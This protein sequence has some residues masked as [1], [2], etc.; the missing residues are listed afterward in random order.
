MI[1]HTWI[2]QALIHDLL[3]FKSNRVTVESLEESEGLRDD[4]HDAHVNT[5]TNSPLNPAKVKVYDLD[6]KDKLW[7]EHSTSPFPQAALAVSESLAEYNAKLQE[8][9]KSNR[10]HANHFDPNGNLDAADSAQGILTAVTE[11]PGMTERK[12]ALDAHTC[13]ATA[14][15]D[16]IKSRSLDGYFEVEQSIDT[17]RESEALQNVKKLL[18]KHAPGTAIDKLRLLLTL[19]LNRPSLSPQHVN[20]LETYLKDEMGQHF[21]TSSLE[22]LRQLQRFKTSFQTPPVSSSSSLAAAGGGLSGSGSLTGGGVSLS[23]APTAAVASLSST[24]F[25]KGR[26]LLQGVKNFLPAKKTLP[27][28]QVIESLIENSSSNKEDANFLYIDPAPRHHPNNNPSHSSHPPHRMASPFRSAVAFVLG[29]GSFVES[30]AL[31]ELSSKLQ[32]EIV[33]GSTDFVSPCD[34]VDEL[35]YL[36]GGGGG[37]NGG[38]SF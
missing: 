18:G 27:I 6:S 37:A 36:G 33:Y 35:T 31:R 19:F 17:D 1:R 38:G 15:V 14:L 32:K 4:L 11:L 22:F 3:R 28:A 7:I 23:A 20:D 26:G 2:Y 34:F 9:N 12:R 30:A 10:L 5:K 13:I 21:P 24:F 25:D 16:R 29:G 8:L